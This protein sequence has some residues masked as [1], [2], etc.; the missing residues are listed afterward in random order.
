[1]DKS[2]MAEYTLTVEDA[3]QAL[4]VSK[5]RIRQHV[6]RGRLVGIMRAGSWFFKPEAVKN[7]QRKPQGR[8]KKQ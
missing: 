8:P 4:G 5:S 6:M 3:A 1:M 7:F 2:E